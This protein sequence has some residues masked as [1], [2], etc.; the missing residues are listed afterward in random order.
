[1]RLVKIFK[2]VENNLWTLEEE[3]NKWIEE[4]GAS[5]ISVTGN[6]APQTDDPHGQ[7]FSASDILLVVL[8]ERSD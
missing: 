5:V 7:A 2:N 4:T 8:Y 6:I 1:M 3:I